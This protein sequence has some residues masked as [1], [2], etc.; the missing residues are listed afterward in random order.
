MDEDEGRGKSGQGEEGEA[1]ERKDSCGYKVVGR[2]QRYERKKRICKGLRRILKQQRVF[3]DLVV[4]F[5]AEDKLRYKRE[6]VYNLLL[7]VGRE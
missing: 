4:V 3:L 6:K 2:S 5:D 1:Y 7:F